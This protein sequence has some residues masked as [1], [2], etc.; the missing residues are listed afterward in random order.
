[1][2][3]NLTQKSIFLNGEGD[4]WFD[5]NSTLNM[6]DRIRQ[7]HILEEIRRLDLEP[8]SVVEIGC[9]EGWRLSE[10]NKEYGSN[11]IGF[12]PSEKA[13]V[14]GS[15]IYPKIKLRVGTADKIELSD[16]SVDLLIV[17]F[18]L[19][20]CD[21]EELF[22]IAK[23]IDRVL[24]NKGIIM[25]LDFY[26]EVPYKNTYSHKEGIYSYKMDYS[27][28]FTWNPIYSIVLTKIVSHSLETIVGNKDERICIASLRKSIEDAYM[29]KPEF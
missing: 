14:T 11:C 18:C 26:S 29:K 5:R 10:I 20:L 24:M 21:R 19:Y 23:E 17:G 4:S 9:A 7:D 25:I 2:N 15:E 27:S 3:T 1:M 12:D 8:K 6:E 28:L 13:I 22:S 16:R